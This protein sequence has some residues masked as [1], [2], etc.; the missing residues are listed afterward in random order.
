MEG[1]SNSLRRKELYSL[2]YNYKYAL[3]Y[4]NLKHFFINQIDPCVYFYTFCS[5]ISN[6]QEQIT[7]TE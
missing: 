5:F 6:S 4:I 1:D 3:F 2:E 7:D